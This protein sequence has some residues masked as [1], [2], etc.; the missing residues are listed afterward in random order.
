MH[1]A[2]GSEGTTSGNRLDPLEA[3][4]SA[5]DLLAHGT[6]HMIH[7]GYFGLFNPS[8]TFPAILAD[9]ITAHFNPQLAVWSHAP[10]AVELER[11]VVEAIGGLAGWRPD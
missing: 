3:S 11:H 10:A 5:I 8:V 4:R 2:Q 9:Q 6:V 1:C 7:P